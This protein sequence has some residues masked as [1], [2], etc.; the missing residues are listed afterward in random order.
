MKPYSIKAN[1]KGYIT[2][3]MLPANHTEALGV[4]KVGVAIASTLLL[5]ALGF[6]GFMALILTK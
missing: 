2:T 4:N 1:R 3:I 6:I 5:L